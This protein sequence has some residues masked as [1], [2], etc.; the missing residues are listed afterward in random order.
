MRRTGAR[1]ATFVGKIGSTQL[2]NAQASKENF[3]LFQVL[4]AVCCLNLFRLFLFRLSERRILPYRSLLR[5]RS[6]RSL[7]IRAILSF[8]SF[9]PHT[10]HPPFGRATTRISLLIII[11]IIIHSVAEGSL[12]FALIINLLTALYTVAYNRCLGACR[13]SER[14]VSPLLSHL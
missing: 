12:S 3:Q 2:E 8:F 1:G 10:P 4:A 14:R 7:R 9:L 13:R 6:A 5:R 11:I